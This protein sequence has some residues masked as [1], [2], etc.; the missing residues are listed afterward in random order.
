[1][2]YG[3]VVCDWDTQLTPVPVPLIAAETKATG[4][5]NAIIR[6]FVKES[7]SLSERKVWS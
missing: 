1:M 5:N 6:N 3:I 2:V 4:Q 7:C